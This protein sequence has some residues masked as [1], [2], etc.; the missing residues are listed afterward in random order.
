[1]NILWGLFGCFVIIFISF[2]LSEKKK[3]INVRTVVVGFV[4]QVIFGYIV[5]KWTIGIK[6]MDFL[7]TA[8]TEI[9]NFG[10]DGLEFAF[11]PLAD[12]ASDIS[13]WAVTVLGMI[14]FFTI[15]IALAYH[16]GIMQHV[17]RFLGGL[18]SKVMKTSYA[19]SVAAAANMFIGNTQAP[20]VVKPYIANMTR[21]Q[22]FS[23]MVGSLASV[24]GAVMVGL[25][26]M[27]IPMKYLLSA[28]VMSAPAGLMIAKFVIPETAEIKDDEWKEVEDSSEEKTNLIDVIFVSSREGLQY[29]INVGL[30]IVAFI[31]LV[32]LVNGALGWTGS[33]FGFENLSLELIFGYAFAPV[34]FVIGIP[35][36]EAVISGNFL[37]QKLFLNEFVAFTD[38]AS[39][40]D[41]VSDKTLA[42]LT[43][44]LSGFAN[45]GA[46]GSIVGMLSEMVPDRKIE[47]QKLMMKALI[48]ATLANLLNGAIV[49]MFF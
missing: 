49:T 11:G 38:L 12:D 47:I 26:A 13:I 10:Y 20:L 9:M 31:S 29:A 45:F 44:S 40:I 30:M 4:A 37:A 19:E 17:V 41:K 46:A 43:F 22:I 33:L 7:S 28:A 48:C 18:I 2:L 39:S 32:A 27:G 23:L 36:E 1:M 42:V 6:V 35:W 5:L 8:I 3:A 25:A 24:S 14:V 16:F 34:A 21:S 15:L